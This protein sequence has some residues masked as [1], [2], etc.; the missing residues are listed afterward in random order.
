M[1]GRFSAHRGDHLLEGFSASR[2]QALF[3]YLLLYR[4]QPHV[5]ECLADVLW[6]ESAGAQ[7][8]KNLRQVLW[9]LQ[10]ALED[11]PSHGSVL[12]VDAE[13]VS[14]RPDADI[15]VDVATFERAFDEARGIAGHNLSA[16][17]A[18]KLCH[19]V[20]LYAGDL[21]P[22]SYDDW[23]LYERERLQNMY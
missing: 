15:W 12:V 2:V 10:T 14:I 18:M 5:R 20:S 7:C 22:Q 17:Q 16:E 4:D 13:W 9:Q 19:A 11:D 23:C 6:S 21:L 3:S 8:R 1:F